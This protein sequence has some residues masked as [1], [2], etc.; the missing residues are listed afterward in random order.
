MSKFRLADVDLSARL[1]SEDQYQERLKQLQKKISDLQNACY[2]NGHRVV[3]VLEG[4]D[5]SGKGGAIRRLTERL[6]PRSY[7]VHPIGKPDGRETQEHY[8]QR[9]W[10]RL[11]ANGLIAIFDR[12][13]YGR[14]LVERV[15]GFASKAAWRRA[16]DEIRGFEQLL[17]NDGMVLIKLMMHISQDEQLRRYSERLN[18]PKKHWKLTDDDLRNRSQAN[19]YAEAYEDMLN[20]THTGDAPWNVIA[21]EYKWFARTA[22]ID[23]VCAAIEKSIDTRI[24]QFSAMEILETKKRLGIE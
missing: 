7:R 11:P 1:D 13:W 3:I 16:Y 8:L 18:N 5:A 2:H 21:A 4:W 15:E 19:A 12:S 24:P 17:T 14:V 6:D 10:R 22:V 9:F 23:T 20:M